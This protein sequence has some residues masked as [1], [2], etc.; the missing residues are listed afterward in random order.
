MHEYNGG[1]DI[2]DGLIIEQSRQVGIKY[3]WGT[4]TVISVQSEEVRLQTCQ[5]L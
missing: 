4:V 3:A 5:P 2:P 1:V